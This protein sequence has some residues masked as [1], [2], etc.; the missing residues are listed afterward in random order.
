VSIF[1]ADEQ[2]QE[3]DL[4][5]LR[6]LAE[7]V[8]AEEG[9]PESSEVTVLL[10]SDDEMGSYNQRFLTRSG[11]TDVLAFPVEDLKPGVAP[12]RDVNDPPL[13]LG[14]IIVAPEYI[15]R[16]AEEYGVTF[17]DEISLM[18]VHGLLHLLGYDH[19]TDD[20]AEMMET[21]ERQILAKVG[22]VRR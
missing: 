22:K 11:P 8:V 20:E 10:V 3:V 4:P 19:Q 7:L 13:L 6:A 9:F 2:T 15:F 16:Q 18:V 21:R 17:D 14:D 5:A 1:V 12:E